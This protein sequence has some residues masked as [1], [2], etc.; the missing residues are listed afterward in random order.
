VSRHLLVDVKLA[1]V[2]LVEMNLA[3]AELVV[4]LVYLVAHP[5]LS[6]ALVALVVASAHLPPALAVVPLVELVVVATVESVEQAP[7]ALLVQ[8][9]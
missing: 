1:A 3:A 5:E 4:N 6:A 7:V 9:S 8:H 2:E